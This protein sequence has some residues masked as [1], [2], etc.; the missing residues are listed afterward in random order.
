[1]NENNMIDFCNKK[2]LFSIGVRIICWSTKF[3][4]LWWSRIIWLFWHVCRC[5]YD[6]FYFFGIREGRGPKYDI[7]ICSHLYLKVKSWTTSFLFLEEMSM[8]D[9]SFILH[10]F[11]FLCNFFLIN[12]MQIYY[13]IFD[14]ILISIVTHIHIT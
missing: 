11:I 1:M 8:T 12:L 2:K 9:F 6:I 4:R 5:E 14:V 13:L 7:F 3:V 10:N